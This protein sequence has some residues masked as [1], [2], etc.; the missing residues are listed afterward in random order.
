MRPELFEVFAKFEERQK[1]YE[2]IRAIYKYAMD[3]IG[4][5]EAQTLL[6]NYSRFEKRFGIRHGNENL[7]VSKRKVKYEN[8][9]KE[10]KYN[11]DT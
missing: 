6:E 9:V 7:I 8:E 3:K 5:S 1:K 2:R 11:Y 10:D 4:K